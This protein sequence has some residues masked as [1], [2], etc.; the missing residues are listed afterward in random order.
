MQDPR[1]YPKMV[2]ITYAVTTVV[3]LLLAVSG[4]LMFGNTTMQE[5]TSVNYLFG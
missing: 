2:N 5:V 4:Y 3:Y 1:Q